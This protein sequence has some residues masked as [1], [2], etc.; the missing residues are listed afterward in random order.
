MSTTM[1]ERAKEMEEKALNRS[2]FV[3]LKSKALPIM[4]ELKMCNRQQEI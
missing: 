3:L 1:T 2:F 4:H